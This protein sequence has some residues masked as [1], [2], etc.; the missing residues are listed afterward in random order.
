M[1]LLR[2]FAQIKTEIDATWDIWK[3]SAP[4]HISNLTHLP[5]VWRFSPELTVLLISPLPVPKGLTC[6]CFY[7]L[8]RCIDFWLTH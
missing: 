6:E 5:K 4:D 8:P 1:P 2:M 3:T 7:S